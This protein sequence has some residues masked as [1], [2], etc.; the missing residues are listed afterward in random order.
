MLPGFGIATAWRH[1]ASTHVGKQTRVLAFDAVLKRCLPK[2]YG[3]EVTTIGCLLPAR[4][5]NPNFGHNAGNIGLMR[6]VM[7]PSR[8][9]PVLLL[10]NRIKAEKYARY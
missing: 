7:S 4:G 9:V 1:A 10:F 6:S 3:K 8:K 5:Y 2:C